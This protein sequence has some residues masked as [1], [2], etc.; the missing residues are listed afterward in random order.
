MAIKHRINGLLNLLLIISYLLVF[1][2]KGNLIPQV[3]FEFNRDKKW[4]I[5]K[6]PSVD[7]EE[8]PESPDCEDR[9]N[10]TECNYIVKLRSKFYPTEQ[11]TLCGR[12]RGTL[13]CQMHGG[14]ANCLLPPME[15]N[16]YDL[17]TLYVINHELQARILHLQN[18]QDTGLELSIGIQREVEQIIADNVAWLCSRRCN[19]SSCEFSADLKPQR[20]GVGTITRMTSLVTEYP[21]F[22]NNKVIEIFLPIGSYEISRLLG[23]TTPFRHLAVSS[24]PL[25]V[26]CS[27]NV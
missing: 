14:S 8:F 16:H 11:V 25:T 10:P 19:N 18:Q 5:L 23:K 4:D 2:V 9:I 20:R 12:Q 13:P 3:E 1:T 27:K 26:S 6:E 21:Y 17:L 22:P 24:L 7:C 15:I